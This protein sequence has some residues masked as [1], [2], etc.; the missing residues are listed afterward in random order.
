MGRHN[1]N[2]DVSEDLLEEPNALC[3][4]GQWAKGTRT[5]TQGPA[6]NCRVT[7]KRSHTNTYVKASP[8]SIALDFFPNR[9][10]HHIHR[11]DVFVYLLCTAP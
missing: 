7:Q 2:T 5:Q 6:R 9:I 3:E 10:P 4:G 11:L 1:C 8:T